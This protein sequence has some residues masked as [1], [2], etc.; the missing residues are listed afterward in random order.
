MLSRYEQRLKLLNMP[1]LSSHME[2]IG[3]TFICNLVNFQVDCQVD[4]DGLLNKLNIKINTRN[5]RKT[6]FFHMGNYRINYAV[7]LILWIIY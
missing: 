2:F 6:D 5:L 1:T 7:V 3:L 4:C